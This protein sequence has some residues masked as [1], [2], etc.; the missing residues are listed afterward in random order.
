MPSGQTR[1]NNSAGNTGETELATDFLPLGDASDLASLESGQI[2]RVKL[3]RSSLASFGLP[4][5]TERAGEPIKA[6]VV[7]GEDGRARAIR[8]VR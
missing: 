3:P 7:L 4:L 8:F 5:N 6:D 1:D 2:V